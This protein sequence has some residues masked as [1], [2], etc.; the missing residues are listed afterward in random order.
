MN[1]HYDINLVRDTLARVI[2]AAGA[3]RAIAAVN[4]IEAE[5]E[6]LLKNDDSLHERKNELSLKLAAATRD[7]ERLVAENH[8]LRDA[9]VN[10][11]ADA[12]RCIDEQCTKHRREVNTMRDTYQSALRNTEAQRDHIL[13]AVAS[14]ISLFPPQVFVPT[15][16][17]AKVAPVVIDAIVEGVSLLR[18]GCSRGYIYNQLKHKFK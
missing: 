7:K 18:D 11:R 1:F 8:R 2:H 6:K 3:T 13:H 4:R 10:E 17:P 16:A 12:N 5:T 15:E 14:R 9:L